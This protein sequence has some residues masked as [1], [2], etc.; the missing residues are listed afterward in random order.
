[1]NSTD[2]ARDVDTY[3]IATDH[4]GSGFLKCVWSKYVLDAR[5]Y[6]LSVWSGVELIH[7]VP[8]VMDDFGSLQIV[9]K[10]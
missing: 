3:L 5:I 2:Y 6:W 9:S 7:A 10:Q 4:V 8:A 1:M